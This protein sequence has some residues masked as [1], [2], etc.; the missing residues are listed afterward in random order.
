MIFYNRKQ[1]P[2]NKVFSRKKINFR[3]ERVKDLWQT[4]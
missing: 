2:L 4:C 1:A 3:P